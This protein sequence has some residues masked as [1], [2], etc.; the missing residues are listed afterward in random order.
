M[1]REKISSTLAGLSDSWW[2]SLTCMQAAFYCEEAV[3]DVIGVTLLS[4][5]SPVA[6]MDPLSAM[7][8]CLMIR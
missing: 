4:V 8:V 6:R 2:S 1:R 5:P 7:L 3:G